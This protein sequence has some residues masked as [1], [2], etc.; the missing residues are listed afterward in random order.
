MRLA[1]DSLPFTM[2]I[3]QSHVKGSIPPFRWSGAPELEFPVDRRSTGSECPLLRISF[4]LQIAAFIS[5]CR[6]VHYHHLLCV[7]FCDPRESEPFPRD[8]LSIT[9]QLPIETHI[10]RCCVLMNGAD[11]VTAQGVNFFYSYQER[12]IR[13]YPLCRIQYVLRFQGA[14]FD[15]TRYLLSGGPLS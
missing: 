3:G 14:H 15:C 5:I 11:G 6:G 10:T 7:R 1:A 12:S 2:R 13:G 9:P 8:W 4:S